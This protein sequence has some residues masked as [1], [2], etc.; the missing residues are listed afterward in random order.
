MRE[1]DNRPCVV[2]TL[3][4]C[5]PSACNFVNR[6]CP[7]VLR[8][9]FWRWTRRDKAE[10]LIRNLSQRLERSTGLGSPTVRRVCR[11]VEP[12]PST[13]TARTEP[14]RLS[15][16]G[17]RRL[18]AHK[19]LPVLNAALEAHRIKLITGQPR[20]PSQYCLTRISQL[21]LQ[22]ST[23]G[24]TSPLNLYD[25]Q[26]T[27]VQKLLFL[28]KIAIRRTFYHIIPLNLGKQRHLGVFHGFTQ[29]RQA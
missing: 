21:C 19:Q 10:R 14:L 9:G 25:E 26:L 4:L 13:A 5:Q 7:R 22:C 16:E 2:G 8:Q 23:N 18:N 11:N 28:K 3:C 1:W 27:V 12:W 24:G 29:K 20:S 17:F 15:C 6:R